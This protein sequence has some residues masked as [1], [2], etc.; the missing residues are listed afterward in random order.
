MNLNKELV[1][2]EE[3]LK[4]VSDVDV[5]RC[6]AP[7]LEMDLGRR[8]ISPLRD[9]KNASFALFAS[10]NEILFKDFVL[11]GGDCIRFVQLLFGES[12]FNAMSR[13]VIDF[14]LTDKFIYR[15]IDTNYT[16]P[17]EGI[18]RAEVMEKAGKALIQIRRRKWNLNDMR[19]WTPF[20]ITLPTLKT[21][22]V[23]PLEFLFINDKI[24]RC[25]NRT[26]AFIEYKDG[27]E[28][29]KIYQPSKDDFKWINNHDESVWQGWA[30]L[31]EKGDKLIIT[32]SLK[33]VMTI[34]STTGIPAVSLQA[35]SVQPKDH[36]IEELKERFNTIWLWYDNDFD[37][38][39]NWGRE[40]GNKIASEYDLLQTEI[41]DEYRIKDPSDFCKKH[42]TD[43]TT[44]LI[45]KLTELPF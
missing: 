17:K 36:I 34:Y 7:D 16:P 27:I 1:T 43:A 21:F 37:S 5:Y 31:P 26:Y 25:D 4:E 10:N 24:I 41:P 35:E 33:D 44:K 42:G 8:Q 45:K 2:K 18:N 20:G 28:T 30:Q 29:Y 39:T 19:F 23:V 9:E 11:G 6:Y 12:F 14:N 22:N 15:D 13:I 40:F 3:L 38:E 32:K